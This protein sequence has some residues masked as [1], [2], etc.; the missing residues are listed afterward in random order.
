MITSIQNETIKKIMKLKQKKYRDEMNLYLIEG[1]H[2]V[3]EARKHQCIRYIITTLDQHFDEETLYVSES[4]MKKLAFTKTPQPIMAVCHKPHNQQLQENG[5]RYVLLDRV[6]DPG[7][8]GTIMR[9]ALAFGYDQIIMS[10]DCVDLYNDK[11]VRATQGALFQMNVCIMNLTEAIR[12]LQDIGVDVYGTCLHQAQSI[13]SYNSKER[14][15]FIMG[16]EG[17]GVSE[18]I[19]GLCNHRLYIP[20]QTVESLNVAIAAAV[21]MYHFQV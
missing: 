4:I 12:F 11:V 19:L 9:T 13:D 15:A 8:V 18:D 6:Q 21:T 14:M 10:P 20:I 5:K 17:Q 7:N 2:L 1:F 3:E 16:N